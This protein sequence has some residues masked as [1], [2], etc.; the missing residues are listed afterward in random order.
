LGTTA[1]LSEEE[2]GVGAIDTHHEDRLEKPAIVDTKVVLGD[3]A[4]NQAMLKEP[5]IP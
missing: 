5:P 1:D 3:E 4:F 2:V